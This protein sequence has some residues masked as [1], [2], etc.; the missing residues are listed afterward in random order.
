MRFIHTADWHLGRL[1][2]SI[3]LTDDQRFTLDGLLRLVGSSRADAVVIAGDVFDRAVPPPDAVR[4]LDSVIASLALDLGVAVVM[5]AG[6]HDSAARLEYFSELARRTGVHVVGRVGRQARAAEVT[7][8]DG[9]PVR[10]WPLAYTDPESARDELQR[11]DVHTHDQAVA[12]QLQTIVRGA[13]GAA[14]DVV[15]GHAFVAGCR[16]CESER[17]LTV[18]GT[19]AVNAALFGDFDYVALG[20]LHEAQTAGSERI[21]Y[22]GSLLKYSFSETDQQKSVNVVDLGAGGELC[23]EQAALPVRRD[24]LRVKGPFAELLSREIDERLAEAYVE[25]TL[26]D[27]EAIAN[28]VD[29]L[30]KKFPFLL[31]LRREETER[32]MAGPTAGSSGIKTRSTAELFG[33]FFLDVS[34]RAV[35]DTQAAEVASVLNALERGAREAVGR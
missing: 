20:H 6:N 23:I 25:V 24:V 12:A 28:P 32:A 29:K 21:R 11:D 13:G 22:S 33:D 10:F 1:F 34:G 7:G 15:V 18:G 9:V 5:I 17:E 30:R 14:R 27:I 35:S 31:S 8:R 2:H 26:T 3:H 16:Q 4:L 19:A